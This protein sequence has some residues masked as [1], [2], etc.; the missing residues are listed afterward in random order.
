MNHAIAR[1]V[2]HALIVAAVAPA[3]AQTA[4]D[5]SAHNATAIALDEIVVTAQKRETNLQD[6]PISV[7]VLTADGLADRHAISL[8]SLADGSIPSLRVAPFATRSSALNIGIRG[9]GASGDANQPARDAGVGVYV[10]GVFLGR[11]QGLGTALHDV[12][13]IEV[14]KGPQGTLFGRNTEGGAISIVTKAPTGAF[15]LDTKIDL[16]SYNGA[17]TAVHLDLPKVSDL[18]FKID[19]LLTKRDGTTDNRMRGEGDFNSYDKRGV[20]V[21]GLWQP[22]GRFAATYAYDNSY[23]ATTPYHA[24]LL[25][26]GPF[27]SALQRAGASEKRRSASILGGPQEDNIGRALGH[28]LSLQWTLTDAMELKSISSY[29]DLEQGQFDQGFIDAISTFSPNGTFGRYSLAQISQYQYSEELQLIGQTDQ[30]QYVAGAFYY[31]ESAGDNAQTPLTN[32]WDATGTS[33]TINPANAPLNLDRV[34]VDRASRAWTNS[35]GMFGQATWTP[36]SL[37]RLHVTAGG[38]YTKDDKQ[39]KL[40]T[41]NGAASTLAFDNA[42]SRFDPM[43]NVA[44][45]LGD[46]AM[47]YAKWSTGFKAGGANSRSLTYRAFD[48]E[49]VTAVELGLKSQFWDNRA[50][51]NVALFDST[52][53][54]KQ[55]DFFFPFTVGGSPRTVSDTTNATTDGESRGAEVEFSIVPVSNLTVSLNYTLTKIDALQAPNPYVNGN[56]LSTVLPLYAPKNAGSAAIDYRLPLGSSTL[57]FHV[58]GNWSDGYYTSEIEQTETDPSLVVNARIALADLPLNSTGTT[59]E[60]ALWSRNLLDEEHLF[61]KSNSA[62]LGTY[63]IFN[64]PRTYGIEARVPF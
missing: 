30:I 40:H 55:M 8:A 34:T 32:L 57:K 49:E 27:A 4:Q 14:L 51:L 25:R 54:G 38:R 37:Q 64:D 47:A 42:W 33:Y 52:I 53:K 6:T 5:S 26:A 45:D 63:G 29:R 59:V 24:Q 15:H 9:I 10:D 17:G 41:L 60:F 58:D 62:T 39:G 50:R 43:V 18:S 36:A 11:A 16:S 23:D 28:L 35:L 3:F 20:R 31:K 44:Y 2:A 13:R 61:Y 46:A 21:T 48:P 19:G 1:A 7:S 12:E 22:S 56:P